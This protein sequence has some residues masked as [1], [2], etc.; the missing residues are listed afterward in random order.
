M[1]EWRDK[2]EKEADLLEEINKSANGQYARSM[3][4]RII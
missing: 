2:K 1:D 3:I 4:Q